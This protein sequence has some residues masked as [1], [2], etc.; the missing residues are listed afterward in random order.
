VKDTWNIGA[1]KGKIE[2]FPSNGDS[3]SLQ[4]RKLCVNGKFPIRI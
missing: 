1:V 3:F 4:T 2:I